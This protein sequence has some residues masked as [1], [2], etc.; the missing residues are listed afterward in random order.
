MPPPP[1]SGGYSWEMRQI[2]MALNMDHRR[3]T[4]TLRKDENQNLRVLGRQRELANCARV[5]D[6]SLAVAARYR[7]L[8]GKMVHVEGHRTSVRIRVV[9]L[10]ASKC[11]SARARARFACLG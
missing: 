9:T 5:G 10:R 2:F 7:P 8:A 3:G 1:V 4:E 6:R 11:S